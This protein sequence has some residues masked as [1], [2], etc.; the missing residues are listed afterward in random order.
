MTSASDTLTSQ[1]RTQAL[2]ALVAAGFLG[3][4]LIAGAQAQASWKPSKTIRLVVPFAPGGASDALDVN[5]TVLVADGG[6]DKS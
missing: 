3:T 4:A 5:G 1:H 6:M 2:R